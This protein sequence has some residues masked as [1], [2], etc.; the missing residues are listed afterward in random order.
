VD[1]FVSKFNAS[2]STLLYSTYLGGSAVENGSISVDKTGDAYIAGWTNSSDFPVTIGAFD[3][4]YNGNDDAF[5]TKLSFPSLIE[6]VFY[7]NINGNLSVD[8]GDKIYI[9]FDKRMQ[10]TGASA[11]DFSL[12]VTGNTLGVG[13]TVS[14]NSA[15]DTQ[16]EITLGICT[17]RIDG[18]FNINTTTSGSPSGID[19]SYS[20]PTGHIQSLDGLD[21]TPSGVKDILYT[22]S[23]AATFVSAFSAATVMVSQDTI[24]D[25]YTQHKLVIPKDSLATSTTITAGL[26]GDNH[27][28]LSAVSF[29]PYTLSFDTTKPAS[30]VIEYKNGDVRSELGYMENAMRIHQW[31]VQDNAW[32]MLP[33]TYSRQS[34]DTVTKTVSVKIDKL[35]MVG[36]IGALL[37][38]TT[39]V[40]AN[41]D[42]PTVGT[43]TANV[44]SSHSF[45]SS[46]TTVISIKTT[47]IYTKHKL[48]LTDY[49]TS[50]S[51][52][53]IILCQP[54]L[55][56]KHGWP[57]YAALKIVTNGIIT[58]SAKLTMEYKDSDDTVYHQYLSDVSGGNEL[59]MRMYLW[60]STLLQW[61]QI[62]IQDGS[63][64]NNTITATLP[65]NQLSGTQIYA[66]KVD[67]MAAPVELSRF[68]AIIPKEK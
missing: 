23:S 42:L 49:I 32:V 56:E 8:S 50:Y 52:V 2:G 63:P 9:Q 14:I 1:V 25:Y 59:Q 62:S 61:E 22:L 31:K 45:L 43:T 33:E 7:S 66:L 36:T 39:I 17:L 53:T 48:T 27:G 5:L 41:I 51:G 21:A 47:G 30:L 11:S 19:I 13:A 3:T 16:V 15:N 4:S 58:T 38:N 40:Y 24:N 10:V 60:N 37:P 68:E 57:N 64:G 26:P 28:A 18:V 46:A 65:A 44:A 34:V 55:T 20:M 29:A 35:N 6:K 67:P 54:T 12:P